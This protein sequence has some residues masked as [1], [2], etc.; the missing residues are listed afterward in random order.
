M[1]DKLA[2]LFLHFQQKMPNVPRE[3][4]LRPFLAL[5]FYKHLAAWSMHSFL[6]GQA[7][8]ST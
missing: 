6:A 5:I 4:L 1:A 7:A 2:G 8:C 3:T